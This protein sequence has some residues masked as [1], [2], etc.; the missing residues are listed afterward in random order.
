LQQSALTE[1]SNAQL[2]REWAHRKQLTVTEGNT[3]DYDYI[4]N[5]I[6][7]VSE[8][9]YIQEIAY[10]QYNATQWAINATE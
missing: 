6:I 5:D 8:Q 1:N 10:D 4:L 7:K 9:L 3:V 2:Y